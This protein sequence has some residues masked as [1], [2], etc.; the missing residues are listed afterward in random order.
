[1]PLVTGPD[2]GAEGVHPEHVRGLAADVLGAHVDDARQA[3]QRARGRGRDAMLAGPRLGDHPGLAEPPGE[4]RL[5]ERVVHLVRAG[6]GQVLALEV[7][8]QGLWRRRRSAA[9]DV[10]EP[11]VG[12]DGL[13]EA[14]GAVDRR[15][16]AG[17][18]RQALAQL[19][20]EARVVAQRGV[21]PLELL[22]GCHERLRH[23]PPAELAIDA[24]APRRVG[25]EQAGM[26]RASARTA[27]WADRCAP[28]ERASRT[29]RLGAGPCV[30]AGRRRAAPRRRTRRRPRSPAR[31]GRPPRP[32]RVEAARED[33]RHLPGDGCG[34][35]AI[36]PDAGAARM[37]T[38]RRV[39][40]HAL[41]AAGRQP[42]PDA[43]DD[44]S[45]SEAISP[46]DPPATGGRWIAFHVGRG[47]L[48]TV[49][50]GSSPE[51]WTTSGSRRRRS[52]PAPRPWRRR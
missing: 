42:G 47:M 51:N 38:T 36:D 7:E 30:A 14:V 44:S 52:V 10:E 34:E 15:R 29:V 19:G 40:E 31:P 41:A 27:C 16:A 24:P 22:E 28:P 8:P 13:G 45:V 3:E 17:V 50:I 2:L 49:A 11:R 37:E 20:P 39:E 23:V 21:G 43:I 32:R 25:I 12:Q 35:S 5:P 4:Q 18:G 6:V 9:A 26:D 48:A 33:D 46:S 1:M